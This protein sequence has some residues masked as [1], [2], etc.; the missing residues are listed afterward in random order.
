MQEAEL[1]PRY[2]GHQLRPTL[3]ATVVGK[4]IEFNNKRNS[5]IV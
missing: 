4:I 5:A 1:F 2:M 3:Q